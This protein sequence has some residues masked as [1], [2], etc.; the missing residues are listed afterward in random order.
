MKRGKDSRPIATLDCETDPFKRGRVPQPFIWGLYRGDTEEYWQFDTPEKVVDFLN[1]KAWIIYAHNG[2]KF[3]YHYL[4]DYIN[5]DEPFMVINQRLAKFKIGECEFRDSMNL[6]PVSLATFEKSTIDYSIM[7]PDERI[8]PHNR[9]LIELY[10]QSD[11]V[12]L[13]TF[14]KEFINQYGM[15]LTQAGAA[16]DYWSKTYNQQIPRQSPHHYEKLKPHYYGGRVQCFREGHVKTDFSVV[17]INSAYP[18]AMLS[19]HPYSPDYQTRLGLPKDDAL[20][21]QLVRVK[22]VSR[23]SLPMRGDDGSLYFPADDRTVR[24]YWTTGWEIRAGLETNTL[25]INQVVECHVFTQ[26]VD[27]KDYVNNFYDMRKK[28][29]ASGDK[30]TDIFAKIFLNSL[31][32]KFASNPEKYS[33]QVIASGDTSTEWEAAGYQLSQSWG[34]RYLM[35]RPI[36][37]D[38]RRYF[39]IATAASVTG[40]LHVIFAVWLSVPLPLG[41]FGD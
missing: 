32:G 19:K 36:P 10:L 3:D 17:D 20:G 30:A 39:N 33:E 25:K 1:D 28:A 13:Y 4:R 37:T 14:V 12:N 21:P 29:K 38:R 11:C 18:H 5:S 40:A 15:H 7:E 35:T 8:K 41:V 27:F 16:M 23:G 2:G 26:L 9:R 22:A 24:D 34:S 31:Y 6:L